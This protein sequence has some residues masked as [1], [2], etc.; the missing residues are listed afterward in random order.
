MGRGAQEEV[1]T[2]ARGPQP[3]KDGVGACLSHGLGLLLTCFSAHSPHH[4]RHRGHGWPVHPVVLWR[5]LHVSSHCRPMGQVALPGVALVGWEQ[6]C[7]CLWGRSTS[8]FADCCSQSW[9]FRLSR[10]GSA[11]VLEARTQ[12]GIDLSGAGRE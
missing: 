10:I 6:R 12:Q 11:I 2:A 7:H 4:G 3:C 1:A 8:Q 9:P 5:L